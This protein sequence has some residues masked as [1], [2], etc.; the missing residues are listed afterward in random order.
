[1]KPF[2]SCLLEHKVLSLGQV[3]QASTV[4]M[5]T[6]SHRPWCLSDPHLW[7]SLFADLRVLSLR[8]ARSSVPRPALSKL[9]AFLSAPQLTE[10]PLLS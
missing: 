5:H 7:P 1:M 8:L 2:L 10:G 4:L 9:E 3:S 6:S